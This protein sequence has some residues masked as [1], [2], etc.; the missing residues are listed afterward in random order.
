[1]SS[2]VAPASKPW[3]K[4]SERKFPILGTTV[5][6]MLGRKV[7]MDS[8]LAALT[9]PTPDHLQVVGPRFAGKTVLVS[10]LARRLRDAGEPY[11]AVTVWDL[12]HQTPS[13]DDLF[14]QCLAKELAA[15]LAETHRDYAEHL[16]SARDNPFGDISEVLELLKGDNQ[17]I[18]LI[19]DGFDKPLSNSHLTRNLW[20]QLRELALKPSLRLITA[21]RRTLRDLLR[22]PDAQTSDFWNI[23]S[24]TPVRVGC[25]NESDLEVLLAAMPEIELSA[26]AKT[27]LWN[28]TNGFP[29]MMLE[30]LNTLSETGGSGSINPQAMNEACVA[31]YPAMRDWLDALWADCS[32]ACQDLLLR[33]REQDEVA[34]AGVP[35]ADAETLIERGF[36]HQSASKLHRANRMLGRLLDE[37]PN[38]GSAV[39]RLFSEAETYKKSLRGV[40][41]RRIAQ[42]AGIDQ[43]LKR[44]LERGVDDFPDHP[45]VF[46][47][48]VHVILERA[49]LLIWQAECWDTKLDKP[50]IPEEWF[51]IWRR[52]SESGFDKWYTSFPEGGQRLRLLDMITGTQRSDR[53]SKFATKN[54][55]VLANA[56]QGFRDFGVHPKAAGISIQTAYVAFH[57][58]I[59]LAAAITS[60]LAMQSR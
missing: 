40:F 32:P 57:T 35:T 12:G 33:V 18:L 56:V 13:T 51:L 1:M 41:E 24:P 4:M 20:D 26:G 6:P 36:I 19:M 58:S 5:P 3:K 42:I 11:I 23:F 16:R 47:G 52:N 22:N 39:S 37:Q 45:E 25:F 59:E 31:A 29:V 38:D 49:L 17:R 50:R 21:S 10:E 43:Q 8:M 46:L 27:E 30:V 7:L 14:M 53:L 2:Q 54:T 34:R 15:A 55:Y 48:S 9:K 28:A 44:A 60:E